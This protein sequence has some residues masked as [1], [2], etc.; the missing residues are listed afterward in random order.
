MAAC[1]RGGP[2]VRRLCSPS[3]GRNP[4][5]ALGAPSPNSPI[6]PYLARPHTERGWE[7][8]GVACGRR[9]RPP[10][11]PFLTTWVRSVRGFHK[12]QLG[13]GSCTRGGG[14]AARRG[15]A[16]SELPIPGGGDSASEADIP[17]PASLAQEIS[18]AHRGRCLLGLRSNRT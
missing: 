7:V 9:V 13:R 1:T 4:S 14:Q 11:A 2:R 18:R 5:E 12:P 16:G 10:R 8:R 6:C 15:A 17:L 3:R